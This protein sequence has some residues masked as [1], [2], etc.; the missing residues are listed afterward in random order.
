[1]S[2]RWHLWKE[3]LIPYFEDDIVLSKLWC[4]TPRT[5]HVIINQTTKL[6]CNVRPSPRSI[7]T[8][9]VFPSFMTRL[10]RLGYLKL[11]VLDVLSSQKILDTLRFEINWD[12][13]PST[14]IAVEIRD[15]NVV[16]SDP[17]ALAN[18]VYSHPEISVFESTTTCYNPYGLRNDSIMVMLGYILEHIESGLPP[19]PTMVLFTRI[20]STMLHR[21]R[22]NNICGNYIVVD[23]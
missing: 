2:E 11:Q 15:H 21:F 10:K 13:I 16:I 12:D 4:A 8:V 20:S 5:H 3:V 22:K 1:M 17:Q 18:F 9:T 7:N 23:P 19:P 6:V 14:V